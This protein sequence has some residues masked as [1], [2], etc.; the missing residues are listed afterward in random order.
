[1]ARDHIAPR[2][3]EGA[4]ISVITVGR[5]AR[6]QLRRMLGDR[7]ITSVEAGAAPSFDRAQDIADLVTKRFENGEAD[8]VTLIYNHFVS[9][10]SQTPTIKQLVPAQ[11]AGAGPTV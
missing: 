5:K 1:M 6:D 8:V 3:V 7:L 9:V 11:V 10:V 4:E 2:T